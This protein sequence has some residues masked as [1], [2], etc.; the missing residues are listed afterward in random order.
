MLPWGLAC[1]Q[2]SSYG[3]SCPLPSDSAP[4]WH[5]TPDSTPAA[6]LPRGQGATAAGPGGQCRRLLGTGTTTL[7]PWALG[8][9]RHFA[10]AG[11]R[12]QKHS[13]PKGNRLRGWS[14][15]KHASPGTGQSGQCLWQRRRVCTKSDQQEH[16]KPHSKMC[17]FV[18]ALNMYILLNSYLRQRLSEKETRVERQATGWRHGEGMG[19]QSHQKEKQSP[20]V[21]QASPLLCAS[22]KK[23][24]VLGL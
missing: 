1:L 21:L 6:E 5:C 4:P 8:D 18:Y 14:S 22:F 9:S 16:S 7:R 3:Q 23:S 10:S 13:P 19:V 11:P 2:V 12:R 24:Q 15:W 17:L 20:K